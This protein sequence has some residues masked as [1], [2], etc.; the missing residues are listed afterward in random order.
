MGKPDLLGL[1]VDVDSEVSGV[2]YRWRKK[3]VSRI[4]VIPMYP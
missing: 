1:A 4:N 3:S 2:T